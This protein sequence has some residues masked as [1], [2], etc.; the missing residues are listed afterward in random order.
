MFVPNFTSDQK[1]NY[2]IAFTLILLFFY[3]LGYFDSSKKSEKRRKQAYQDRKRMDQEDQLFQL[4]LCL[5]RQ[6]SHLDELSKKVEGIK[7]SQVSANAH[8]A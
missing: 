2:G 1:L 7:H 4:R 3:F 5:D 6:S 8:T